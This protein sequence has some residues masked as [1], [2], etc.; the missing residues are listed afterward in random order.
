MAQSTADWRVNQDA[1]NEEAYPILAQD[2]IW[3]SFALAD[4]EPP[5]RDYS[6]FATAYQDE[7]NQHAA[8]LIL[9]HPIIGHLLSPFGAEEGVAAIFDHVSLPE[10]PI[11][12]AQEMH[13]SVLEGYYR[14]ETNWKTLLRMAVP[15]NSML[16][17]KYV[18]HLSS[19]QLVKPLSIT[20]LPALNFFY[21]QHSENIFSPDLFA[22]AMFFGVYEG[23]RIIAAGGTHVLSPVHKVA[24]IGNILTAPEARGR[25][26][27]TA[28][29]ATLVSTLFEQSYSTVVL[30]V[31]EDNYNAIRIY[32][33]LGFRTHHRLVTG[34]AILTG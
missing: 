4:L 8:C 9:R 13:L 3:N 19:H 14:P 6:Q 30:N 12:Q 32:E 29:T 5:F 21:T 22:H 24:V 7:S 15:P 28:I 33:R 26:Y 23:E 11:I 17:L 27:A 16:H 18:P 2:P 10:Y 1:T 20:D 31:F 25:G 34:K